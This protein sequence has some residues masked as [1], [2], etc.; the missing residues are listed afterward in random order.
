[1]ILVAKGGIT[2]ITRNE[3]V[4]ETTKDGYYVYNVKEDIR[5]KDF[6]EKLG[7]KYKAGR[8]Y[9]EWEEEEI[10]R[11]GRRVLTPTRDAIKDDGSLYMVSTFED[12]TDEVVKKLGNLVGSNIKIDPY[13]NGIRR[14]RQLFLQSTSYTRKLRRGSKFLYSI[15]DNNIHNSVPSMDIRRI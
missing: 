12:V 10:V 15:W 5:I 8:G 4:I 2:S 3:D 6:V 13:A 11:P 14:G 9:Y 7:F 1:M